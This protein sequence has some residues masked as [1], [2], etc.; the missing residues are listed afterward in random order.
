MTLRSVDIHSYDAARFDEA[1]L[2]AHKRETSLSVCIPAHD[3]AATIARVVDVAV[4]LARRDV[5]DEVVVAAD[6]C[7]DDTAGEAARAGAAVVVTPGSAPGQPRGKGEAM[8]AALRACAGE[9]VVFL[10]ADVPD[11]GAEFVTGLVGPLLA[12]PEHLLVKATYRRSLYGVDGEGGRVTELVARPLLR[13]LFPPL[14]AL[15]QP[16]AGEVAL[17]RSALVGIDLESGYGVEVGLLIDIFL[18]HGPTAIA[19]VDLGRREHRNRPLRELAGQAETVMETILGRSG[20][21]LPERD[22]PRDSDVG[23]SQSGRTAPGGE[24]APATE[25]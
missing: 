12:S 11:L 9:L 13:R 19:Q 3:E 5:V 24:E 1:W 16:L 23:P 6:G 17:R 10:D 20:R 2:C 15:G 4:G 7:Q 14:G 21:P 18:R 22:T 25:R 8:A